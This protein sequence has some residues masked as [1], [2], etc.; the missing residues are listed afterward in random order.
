VKALVKTAKGPGNIEVKDVPIP[1]LNEPDWVLIK[2]KAAGVCGTDLHIWHD[3]FPYWP[4]VI[5][6]HEFSGEVVETGGKV[7]N[8]KPG[9]RVVAEPHSLSCGLCEYCRQGLVQMCPKKRSPGWG[10]DGAF[11]EYIKMPAQ[12]LHRIPEGIS[13]ELAA[14]AEPLAIAVHQVA[15]QGVVHL[16][17]FVVVTGVGPMGILAAFIAKAQGAGTVLVTG[18]GSGEQIRFPAARQLGAD[19]IVNVEKEDLAARIVELTGGKGADV[20]IETSGA[21]AAIRQGVSL[22]KKRGRIS[23]IGLCNQEEILFPWNAAM[24]KVLDI[25]FNF[26]SSY[27]SW[28]TALGLLKDKGGMLSHLI[29]HRF[30]LEDWE[31]TFKVLEQEKGIKAVYLPN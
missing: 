24:H 27:T 17:D 28:D 16:Q 6:G 18:M 20:L 10:I 4:P 14:L 8:V 19:F 1:V 12:L 5:L 22:L 13:Y 11:C 9:D 31:S 3:Q 30:K 21:A 25:H 23:A 29:T 2:V 26:S 7:S 15:E